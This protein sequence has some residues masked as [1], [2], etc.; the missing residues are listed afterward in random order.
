MEIFALRD[1]KTASCLF[2][3]DASNVDDFE[4]WFVQNLL[5]ESKTLFGTFPED[6]D[7][8]QLCSFDR[9]S[10]LVTTL[11]SPKLICSVSDLFD[12]FHLVPPKLGEF[13]S[14]RSETIHSGE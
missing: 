11:K 6:Y 12:K 8:Y 9:D 3:K 13:S 1:R 2:V 4:R 10:M 14:A 7:I 5:I